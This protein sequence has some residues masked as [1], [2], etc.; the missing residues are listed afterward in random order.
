MIIKSAEYNDLEEILKLQ[1]LAYQSEAI[2][3]NNF[4]IPPLLQTLE[5]IQNEYNNGIFLKAVTETDEII[6][7]VRGYCKLGTMYIGKLIVH[8]YEQGKGIGSKLLLSME[9]QH[10]DLRYELFTSSMSLRNLR[11]Y[12]YLGYQ[13]FKEEQVT[14]ELKF[15]YLEKNVNQ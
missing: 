7:S 3:N 14:D 12:E 2:L 6:G 15:I 1:Y 5:E 11:L 4:K 13:R 8:P 10:A 9:Q